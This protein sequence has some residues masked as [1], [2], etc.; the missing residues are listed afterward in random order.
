[1]KRIEF[2]PDELTIIG[3]Y[4]DSGETDAFRRLGFT[5]VPGGPKRKWPVTPRENFIL[6]L[7]GKTPFWIPYSGVLNSDVRFF[8]PRMN[9]EF[10]VRHMIVDAEPRYNYVSNIMKSSWFDLEWE[11][12]P[13]VGGATVRPGAPKVSD[14]NHWEDEVSVPKIED[15]DFED[16]FNKNSDFLIKDKLNG[17]TIFTGFWER[18][19]SLMDVENAAIAMIDDEQKPGVHRLFDKLAD[20]YCDYITKMQ[21]T[22]NLDIFQ[23][24]DDW[25]HQ[26]ST[27]FSAATAHE[28]LMPYLKRVADCCHSLGI[29]LEIHSCGKNE[30]MVPVY[31]ESGI[32]MWSPQPI[33]D[34]AFLVKEYKSSGLI[35]G[36]P[37]PYIPEDATNTQVR[38]I[39]QQF[40]ED[41]KCYNIVA[42]FNAPPQFFIDS[43]YEF[44]RKAFLAFD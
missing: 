28:M 2:N 34:I 37:E 22:F 29:L 21:K 17:S 31:I 13:A 16:C 44:S 33:N 4:Q 41:Y 9:E 24:H 27:F 38:E 18:L 35:F 14:I 39:A 26:R 19:I 5:T 7:Q 30:S 11:Y 23:I 40:V 1:M 25:V 42:A 43:V 32:D 15:F 8:F 3:S 12:V 6:R 10:I 20:F 36:V